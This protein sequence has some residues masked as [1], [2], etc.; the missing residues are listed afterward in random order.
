MRFGLS[1]P[2][3]TI[4]RNGIN[5]LLK[6]KLEE[7]ETKLFA[8]RKNSDKVFIEQEIDQMTPHKKDSLENSQVK[9]QIQ[10]SI[11]ELTNQQ[12]KSLKAANPKQPSNQ[13][14]PEQQQIQ[15]NVSPQKNGSFQNLTMTNAV[16]TDKNTNGKSKASHRN[17]MQMSRLSSQN[18]NA[19]AGGVFTN[20]S[21]Q[22]ETTSTLLAQH[23][24]IIRELKSYCNTFKDNMKY[25]RD[26]YT[27]EE[28]V[29]AFEQ[30]VSIVDSGCDYLNYPISI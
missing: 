6:A 29:D 19:E 1:C 9:K 13:Q 21:K 12:S 11:N 30:L 25:H 4:L 16:V 14:Q 20:N 22:L 3:P 15:Q 27:P 8:K 18:L 7:W 2:F 28:M 5:Y 23:F 10:P 17:T 24:S 26:S